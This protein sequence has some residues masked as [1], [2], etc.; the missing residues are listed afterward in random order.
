MKRIFYKQLDSM[1]CGAASLKI[2]AECYGKKFSQQHLRDLCHISR[3]GVSLLGISDAAE[4][5]GFRTLGVKITWEQ[6]V[7]DVIFPCIIHWNQRHFIVVL[8][9]KK[10]RNRILVI[11]SDPSIGILEYSEEKF[12]KS[13]I[14]IKDNLGDLRGVALLL[15]PKPEFYSTDVNEEKNVKLLDLFHYLRPYLKY[16]SRI[17]G[18]MLLA[19]LFS[20]LLPY[21][22]QSMVDT[23][24][25][26][27]DIG[28]II[29]VLIAQLLLIIG[30][31]TNNI[32]RSWL[33]LHVTTRIGITYISDF[34]G[35]MMRLSIS[36][37]DSKNIG[38]ILQ[39]IKDFNRVQ[40]FL[41][42]SLISTAMSIISFVIYSIIM[43]VYNGMIL[44]VF[45]IGSILYVFWIQVFMRHRRKLDYMLFQELSSNQNNLI[46]LVDGMQ[47]IK[48]NNCE[49]MKRW[50]WEDIQAR[51]FRINSRSL[52]LQ[53]FQNIGGGLVDQIK[54]ISISFLSAYNVIN[55]QMTIGEMM[56]LQYII[57]Q[58]NAPLH[59]FIEFIQSLQDAK[60]SIER[61]GEISNQK[62]KKI[63]TPVIALYLRMQT[64]L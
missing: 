64:Y 32:I 54:N 48:L 13:W 6:L 56:A 16:V 15:S 61:M 50:E 44:S 39:R 28:F 17:A 38:D 31:M 36:F 47:E 43:G 5:V 58:L 12:K 62:T 27:R 29:T 51:L 14:Q 30:Q 57:G 53:Q 9:L 42:G 52:I 20:L 11:V 45:L 2:I 18:A 35:K 4:A 33:M 23:G 21:L 49:R 55:G 46:Q 10:R 3:N 22:T 41:T 24:I 8:G 26:N 40:T 59:Q 34:I 25:E 63:L 19:S 1:D 7:N 60:I 37:F